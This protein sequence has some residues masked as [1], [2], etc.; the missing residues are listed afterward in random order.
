MNA[1]SGI[2][3]GVGHDRFLP[4]PLHCIVCPFILA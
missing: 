1:F 4:Y 3:I 2:D